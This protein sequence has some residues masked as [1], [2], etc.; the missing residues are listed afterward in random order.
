[1]IDKKVKNKDNQIE[2]EFPDDFYAY[3]K[4][5]VH[6]FYKQIYNKVKEAY[7]IGDLIH[8]NIDSEYIS[9]IVFGGMGGSA[10]VGI[11]IK[12][13]L[14]SID[15][16]LK[17]TINNEYTLPKHISKNALLICVSYSGNTEETLSVFKE[18]Q[19]RKIKI[20]TICSGGKLKELADNYRLPLI[21][22]P[23]G[24]H[25]R[26]SLPFLFF[27][28]IKLLEKLKILED[29]S[30]QV[31][32]LIRVLR[33]K[34][35]NEI[36][37]KLAEKLYN[38]NITIYSSKTLTG[39]VYRWKTQFNENSKVLAHTHIFPELCHNEL[40]QY[41]LKQENLH[42][43]ILKNDKDSRRLQKRMEITK[44]LISKSCE[45]TEIGITGDNEFIKLYTT[46]LIGDLTS[47]YLA[48]KN[49]RDPSDDS[50][51]GSLKKELGPWVN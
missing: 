6:Q 21:E 2:E 44:K 27:P 30:K 12:E 48:I 23:K 39:V 8:T 47:Y 37:I 50:I 11:L 3:D 26:Q 36:A 29:H 14:E 24:M 35:F 17:I 51:I 34:N 7:K 20:I 41:M 43:I 15:C 22:V 33:K 49:R 46:I 13:Y 18:A 42:V 5:D 32:A 16:E 28:L 38:K 19:R 10:I 40:C 4:E 45:V 1:M 31:E 9:E 25:P